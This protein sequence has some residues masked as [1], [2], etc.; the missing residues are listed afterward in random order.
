MW[1]L[2]Q[3][4]LADMAIGPNERWTNWLMDDLALDEMDLDEMVGRR[5]GCRRIGYRLTGY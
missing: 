4:K 3:L 5:N 1:I 2:D